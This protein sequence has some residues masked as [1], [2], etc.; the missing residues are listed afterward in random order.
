MEDGSGAVWFGAPGMIVIGV[1]GDGAELVID[2][3]TEPGAVG[4]PACGVRA[5]PKD[6]RWVTLRDAPAGGRPVRVRWRKRIWCCP[7]P[8][9]EQRTWTE[10]GELAEPRRVLTRRAGRW[11]CDRVAAIE[12]TRSGNRLGVPSRHRGARGRPGH[13]KR[14]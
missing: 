7:D 9:C 2:V 11:A 4:C 13:R 8:D 5:V 6:R 10:L 3:E 14:H 1:A 12:G